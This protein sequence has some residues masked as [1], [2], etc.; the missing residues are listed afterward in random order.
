MIIIITV[1]AVHLRS[2]YEKIIKSNQ[3]KMIKPL[4]QS[5]NKK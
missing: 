5:M 1:S 3:L 2:E 4:Y